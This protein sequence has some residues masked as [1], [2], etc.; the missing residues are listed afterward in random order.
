[1]HLLQRRRPVS[2]GGKD[3]L[4]LLVRLTRCTATTR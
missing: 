1:M 3:N 4:Q 2:V